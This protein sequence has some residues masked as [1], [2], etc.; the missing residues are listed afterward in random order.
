VVTLVS[1][2]AAGLAITVEQAEHV[3]RNDAD[4]VHS[5]A[6][7][8]ELNTRQRGQRQRRLRPAQRRLAD[9]GKVEHHDVFRTGIAQPCDL[10]QRVGRA[11]AMFTD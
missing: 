6:C 7:N 11:V 3:H 5:P 8:V 2:N 4:V 9:V 1:P 10:R